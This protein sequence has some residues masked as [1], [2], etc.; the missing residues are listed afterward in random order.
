M[1]FTENN[2]EGCFNNKIK[3]TFFFTKFFVKSIL[4]YIF[5][6]TKKSLFITKIFKTVHE[7][8]FDYKFNFVNESNSSN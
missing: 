5:F 3:R 1:L 7:E 6:N 2:S 4:I 8:F